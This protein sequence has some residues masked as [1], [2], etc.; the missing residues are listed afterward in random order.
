MQVR[1]FVGHDKH[2]YCY[3]FVV[4]LTARVVLMKPGLQ[5]K[6]PIFMLHPKQPLL[7]IEHCPDADR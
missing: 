2:M 3:R 6:Q 5:T 7:Q 1:Q 4:L